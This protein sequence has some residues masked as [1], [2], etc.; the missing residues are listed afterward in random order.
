[1]RCLWFKKEQP[2]NELSEKY[3]KYCQNQF[4]ISKAVTIN[5]KVCT[6]CVTLH[7]KFKHMLFHNWIELVDIFLF[8]T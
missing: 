5:I 6:G 3:Q 4:V 7:F 2:L 1:M 8:P